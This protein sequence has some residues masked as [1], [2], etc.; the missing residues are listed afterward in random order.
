MKA[1]LII[2]VPLFLSLVLRVAAST[3]VVD[4][5]VDP[6]DGVCSAPGCTLREAITAAN[7]N[8]GPDIINSNIP[9]AGVIPSLQRVRCPQSPKRS[10]STV[11]RSPALRGTLSPWATM[12]SW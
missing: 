9:G 11:I 10:Q 4:N 6:G 3:I 2:T 8:P 12:P 7:A 1:I 5:T